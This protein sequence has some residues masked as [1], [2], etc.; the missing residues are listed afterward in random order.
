[1][2]RKGVMHGPR[3]AF[4]GPFK[5]NHCHQC[6]PREFVYLNYHYKV[7]CRYRSAW[8]GCSFVVVYFVRNTVFASCFEALSRYKCSDD[9]CFV[10]SYRFIRFGSLRLFFEDFLGGKERE[11]CGMEMLMNGR[12]EWVRGT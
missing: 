12:N 4:V 5:D 8:P 9:R 3:A 10:A 1:M 11:K 2:S 7:S 6:P